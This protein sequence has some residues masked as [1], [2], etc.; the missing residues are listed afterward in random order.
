MTLASPTKRGSGFQIDSSE[1]LLATAVE[2]GLSS[3]AASSL[4]SVECVTATR[5][6]AMRGFKTSTLTRDPSTQ[7]TITEAKIRHKYEYGEQNNARA[8]L[9]YTIHA[10]V[11]Y[12]NL[13][14]VRHL[15]VS[16]PSLHS[17]T[18]STQQH[19]EQTLPPSSTSRGPP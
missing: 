11:G 19:Q 17:R 15:D 8:W 12:N 18:S 6:E 7:I 14:E 10:T 16:L 4:H 9:E 3:R 13:H 2:E 1:R 5:C